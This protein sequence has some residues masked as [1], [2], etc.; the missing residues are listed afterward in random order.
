MKK[1]IITAIGIGSILLI[2]ILAPAATYAG[3]NV[4]V[5]VPLPPLVIPAP[6]GLVVVP[7]TYVY[8]PPDV[9]VDIFFYHG[10]WYRPHHGYWYR[11]RSYNGPWGRIAVKRVPRAVYRIP[12][13]FRHGPTYDRVPHGEVMR[14]W[15]GWERDRH[16]ER[17]RHEERGHFKEGGHVGRDRGDFREGEHRGHERGERGERGGGE[18]HER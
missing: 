3:V 6:P 15:R 11:S 10:Y 12:P 7:D 14:N 17:G 5:N 4:T 1:R 16:W 2:S 8:Y 13:G 18:R 9:D